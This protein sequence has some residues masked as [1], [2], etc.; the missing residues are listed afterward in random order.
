MMAPAS[1]AVLLIGAGRMGGALI[2][3]WIAAKSFSAIHVVEPLPSDELKTAA[4]ERV[5]HLHARFAAEE[6]PPLSSIV[7]AVKPQ[8]LKSE[9]TLLGALGK[10]GAL[11]L[12]IAAGI[13]TKHLMAELGPR[14]PLVRAMPNTPGAIGQ[15]ITVLYGAGTLRDTDRA[16]AEALMA[17]LGETLWLTD[18]T[19]MDAVT[20]VSGSGPAYVFLLAEALTE[21]GRA[22]GLDATTADRLA[23][24]TIAGSGALLA[25]VAR[26][27][28]ALRKEVTSPGGTTEAALE[29]LMAPDGLSAL[30][31]RA[32]AA[33][34][35]RGK[36]LGKS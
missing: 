9:T 6:L 17:S 31:R 20:A 1:G 36:A 11:I 34:T 8:V 21:A 2:K 30:M 23:R 25:A 26:P 10:T 19:L 3:G 22:E 15:G 35:A 4:A 27:A 7:L 32:V 13:T 24:A 12:S 14:T 16:L 33:A 29:V 5:V 28:A 18:E